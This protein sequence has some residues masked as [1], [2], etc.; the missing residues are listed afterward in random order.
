MAAGA[1]FGMANML[2]INPLFPLLLKI[3][4]T[5][6][7]LWIAW[8]VA[9]APAPGNEMKAIRPIGYIAGLWMLWHNPKGW[10]MTAAAAAA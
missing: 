9:G 2:L 8:R 1:A 5:L 7:L 4:G 10:A 3:T 6:Y